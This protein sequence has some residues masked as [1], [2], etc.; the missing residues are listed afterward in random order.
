MTTPLFPDLQPPLPGQ[1][2]PAPEE[3]DDSAPLAD[4]MRPRSL[5]EVLGQ[6]HLLGPG[7]ALGEML[8]SDQ[9]TSMIL[10]GPPGTGKTTIARL[11]A[12]GAKARFVELSAV[13][14]GIKDVKRV[15]EEARRLHRSGGRRTVL[16][17]DEI[18]RFNKAQQDA[19]LPHVESGRIVLVGATTENP[20]FEVISPLLSRSRVFVLKSLEEGD[21]ERIL[22][23]AVEDCE[24]GLG[25]WG[26]AAEEGV[27]QRLA[28]FADGDARQALNSLELA[29]Q[30]SRAAD[31]DRPVISM[32]RLKQALQR[33]SIRYDKNGEEHYNLIS[34]L[35]K[36]MRNSDADAALYWLGRMLEAGEDP[37]YI[38]R[39]M[40]RFASEDVGLAD[41]A[42]LGYAADAFQAYEITGLPEG[43]LHLAQLAVYLARA[44]K[45][46]AV[47]KAYKRVA[48]DVETTG[49]QPVPLHLRNAPTRLMKDLGYSEGYRYAHDEEG[50]V[51]DMPCLPEGLRD[52]RYWEED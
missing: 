51:A 8:R 46:N 20:S 52:R 12:K 11:I 23:R 16:F 41:P 29:A 35:H 9:L 14:S 26:M 6:E 43:K 48:S 10:W 50:K 4:R 3:Q 21:L 33:R 39:R 38:L 24:R 25:D 37:R 40:V 28:S 49:A 44:P 5:S 1:D 22:C 17:V 13:L 7:C 47:Y 2:E 45:S 32:D 30:L 18:H 36:S 19:F 27:L 42:A 15:A 31:P 34:A